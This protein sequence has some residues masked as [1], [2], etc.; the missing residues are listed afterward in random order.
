MAA[1]YFSAGS[2]TDACT[3]ISLQGYCVFVTGQ[4]INPW[5][6]LLASNTVGPSLVSAFASQNQVLAKYEHEVEN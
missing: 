5:A 6:V 4:T 2:P 3:L 1:K